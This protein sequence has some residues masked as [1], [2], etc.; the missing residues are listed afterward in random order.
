MYIVVI[1]PIDR[2]PNMEGL[3]IY[4]SPNKGNIKSDTFSTGLIV[5]VKYPYTLNFVSLISI[6]ICQANWHIDSIMFAI[7]IIY[8][9][10][11]YEY[12]ITDKGSVII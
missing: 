5:F 11:P 1:I 4:E 9:E 3:Y 8:G 6:R 10:H 2:I 7:I 12:N